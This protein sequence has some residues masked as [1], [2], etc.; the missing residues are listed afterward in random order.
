MI[1]VI[2]HYIRTYGNGLLAILELLSFGWVYK[3]NSAKQTINQKSLLVYS[4]GYWCLI[5]INPLIAFFAYKDYKS[6]YLLILIVLYPVLLV[7]SYCFAREMEFK[8]W[9][10]HII[11]ANVEKVADHIILLARGEKAQDTKA[12]WEKIFKIYFC[13]MIKYIAPI[14]F[15]YAII[16]Y[17]EDDILTRYKGSYVNSGSFPFG[18]TMI[19]WTLAIINLLIIIIPGLLI[20]SHEK[21][22]FNVDYPFHD[23]TER[24]STRRVAPNKDMSAIQM[25][26]FNDRDISQI[27]N[28][29][30][31]ARERINQ[32]S[33]ARERV[34]TE[35]YLNK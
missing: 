23:K 33:T 18:T 6:I 11:F 19:G 25:R 26:D 15:C 3:F 34:S 28:N 29:M 21:L 30:S 4:I 1:D 8:V 12:W 16:S 20:S 27:S 31:S 2:N 10:K 5:F 17:F 22:G 32:Q 9:F 7:V 13:I 35:Q 24:I 14:I